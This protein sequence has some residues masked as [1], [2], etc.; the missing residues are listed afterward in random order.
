MTADN[1]L[2]IPNNVAPGIEAVASGNNAV[3]VVCICRHQI[4][5]SAG[6]VANCDHGVTMRPLQPGD[7]ILS[8]IILNIGI[9]PQIKGIDRRAQLSERMPKPAKRID[10]GQRLGCG[11]EDWNFH[12]VSRKQFDHV[13]GQFGLGRR[14]DGVDRQSRATKIITQ[15]DQLHGEVFHRG[16]SNRS[17]YELLPF[18]RSN[19]S[20]IRDA[21][22]KPT[23]KPRED[24]RRYCPSLPSWCA[25]LPG[26]PASAHRIQK[27]HSLTPQSVGR[28]SATASKPCSGFAT[29]ATVKPP[30]NRRT[31][32]RE[33]G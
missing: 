21:S 17:I 30:R 23:P 2:I 18:E 5:D 19:D 15:L 8:S 4:H 1:I 29:L 6:N 13:R 26:P 10:Q 12:C 7:F 14:F 33:D 25:S 22:G 16:P 28:H 9:N 24:R 27:F 31:R 11:Y 32:L 3:Q 20:V